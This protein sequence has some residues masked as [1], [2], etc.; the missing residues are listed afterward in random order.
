M[1]SCAR[2]AVPVSTRIHDGS[3]DV[4]LT[5]SLVRGGILSKACAPSQGA[6][7]SLGELHG[8]L[9][10]N[11]L[12]IPAYESLVQSSCSR[13]CGTGLPSNV[14]LKSSKRSALRSSMLVLPFI[15]VFS[16]TGSSFPLSSLVSSFSWI[17][18]GGGSGSGMPSFFLRFLRLFSVNL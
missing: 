13:S 15:G 1:T 18:T 9:F 8:Q 2:D 17:T 16:M 14:K 12:E 4:R 10:S 6:T 11:L 3:L 5:V 7:I